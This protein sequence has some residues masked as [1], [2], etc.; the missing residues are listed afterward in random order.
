MLI[1]RDVAK[2]PN[3]LTAEPSPSM[4]SVTTLWHFWVRGR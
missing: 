3:A 1:A 4:V 2:M